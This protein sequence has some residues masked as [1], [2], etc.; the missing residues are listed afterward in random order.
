MYREREHTKYLHPP[1]HCGDLGALSMINRECT[2]RSGR[3][4]TV[5]YRRER[6]NGSRNREQNAFPITPTDS[7]STA[8]GP[9]QEIPSVDPFCVA[10][11]NA[12]SC[13]S[14]NLANLASHSILNPFTSAL[15]FSRNASY[16][17]HHKQNQEMIQFTNKRTTD[18]MLPCTHFAHKKT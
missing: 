9:G 10:A 3:G 15:C 14:L 1:T 11:A 2:V 4:N 13:S 7:Y 16:A 8:K 17:V 5:K 12:T 6:V 18:T